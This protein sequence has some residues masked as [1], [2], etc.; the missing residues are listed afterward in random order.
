MGYSAGS[1]FVLGDRPAVYISGWHKLV[2]GAIP[3]GIAA[4]HGRI[5]SPLL[6]NQL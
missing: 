4:L 2:A 1:E 5:N 3:Y 6:K